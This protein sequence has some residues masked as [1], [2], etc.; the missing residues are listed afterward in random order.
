MGDGG[1]HAA[2]LTA[3]ESFRLHWTLTHVTNRFLL[4]AAGCA[5]VVGVAAGAP[6]QASATHVRCG[7]TIS[8]DTKLDSDLLDCP[9]DGVSIGADNITLDLAGHTIDGDGSRGPCE[10]GVAN[11]EDP[12]GCGQSGPSGYDGVTI[13]NGVVTQF[14]SGVELRG[15]SRNVL[16]DLN[17]SSN[18]TGI[19]LGDAVESRVRKNT[20]S[21]NGLGVFVSNEDTPDR[22]GANQLTRNL[23]LRN[24]SGVAVEGSDG[25]RISDNSAIDNP[26]AGISLDASQGNG[27]DSNAISGSCNAVLLHHSSENRVARNL[28]TGN[29]CAGIE[30]TDGDHD[31]RFEQNFISRNGGDGIVA[32]GSQRIVGNATFENGA[33]GITVACDFEECLVQ[34]NVSYG[35]EQ[36]IVVR[37]FGN[38]RV[39]QNFARDN[40]QD[41]IRLSADGAGAMVLGNTARQNG[42]D[43]IDVD[44]PVAT[45]TRNTATRNFDFGIEAVPSVIDGGGNR[46]RANGNPAQCANLECG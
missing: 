19:N 30:A 2:G 46:A 10:A 5:V 34:R 24:G 39:E 37:G 14:T 27:I 18:G 43:G 28:L 23:V 21:G 1:G 36:G 25:N 12:N 31:N 4:L 13:K 7:D 41:G 22:N 16:R 3:F 20:L 44:D 29:L 17:A 11:G 26:D 32:E 15:A 45:L 38:T 33:S 9:G 8:Q 35:N 42:D 40:A 6:D